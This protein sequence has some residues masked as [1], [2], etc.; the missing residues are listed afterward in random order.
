MS[1]FGKK[2]PY[3]IDNDGLMR[4]KERKPITKEAKKTAWLYLCRTVKLSFA[5]S[6]S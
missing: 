2:S 6:V 4:K 5:A 3:D 1:L